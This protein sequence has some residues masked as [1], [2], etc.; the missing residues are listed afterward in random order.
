MR[1][2]RKGGKDRIQFVLIAFFLTIKKIVY[3]TK[4]SKLQVKRTDR[5]EIRRILT[6]QKI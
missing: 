4:K 3:A 6:K 5:M 2:R 1:R